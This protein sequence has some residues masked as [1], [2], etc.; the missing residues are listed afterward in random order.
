MLNQLLSGHSGDR[1]VIGGLNLLSDLPL[2]GQA[3]PPVWVALVVCPTIEGEAFFGALTDSDVL[4]QNA[5]N[6][7]F[8]CEEVLQ[9]LGAPDWWVQVLINEE[10]FDSD[11]EFE[12]VH[13]A[14]GNDRLVLEGGGNAPVC[15]CTE[16][17]V[18][19]EDGKRTA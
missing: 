14:L 10:V 15:S 17:V 5:P 6:T 8:A 13:E 9:R 3:N 1:V 18:C 2:A 12:T 7:V 11:V 4:S 16:H 19:D